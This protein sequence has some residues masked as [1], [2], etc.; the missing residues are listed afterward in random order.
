MTDLRPFFEFMYATGCR[1]GAVQKIRWEHV[2]KDCSETK[3]P[4]S[5]TKNRLPQKRFRNDKPVFDSTNY[6]PE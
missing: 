2:T 5:N 1:L 3:I 6:R 4:A